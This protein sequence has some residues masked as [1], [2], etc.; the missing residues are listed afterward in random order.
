MPV[1]YRV[2]DRAGFEADFESWMPLNAL[3]VTQRSEDAPARSKA[4]I[5]AASTR[6]MSGKV[7]SVRN[8]RLDGVSNSE[9]EQEC[10]DSHTS[11]ILTGRLAG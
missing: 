10:C 5:H 2:C 7:G 8:E 9:E 3:M 6:I 1:V 11:T 4:K